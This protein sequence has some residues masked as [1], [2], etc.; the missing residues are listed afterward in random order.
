[1]VQQRVLTV[2]DIC[3]KLKPILGPK[4]DKIY[5]SYITSESRETKEEMAAMIHALYEKHFDNF[6]DADAVLSPPKN[7]ADVNGDYPI[8]RVLYGKKELF[9]FALR[10]HD[11][12][13]HVCISGMSGSGKTTL[14][15]N[16]LEGLIAKDKP[17]LVFDWKKSFRPLLAKDQSLTCFTVG[18]SKLTNNFKININRP[19]K[20]VSPKEWIT[21][22][23]DLVA[24]S[25]FVSYGVHKV[26]VEV[27]DEAFKEWGVYRGSEKYPT[28]NHFKWMLEERLEKAKNR[29]STWIE[30]ALRVATV[31]TFGDFGEVVNYRGESAV[32]VEDIMDRRV[33]FE[34]NALGNIEKKF[35]CEFIL[36]Y[37]YKMRKARQN[38]VD[39]GF[40]YAILVDEAHNIFLKDKTNFVS[41]S[42]TDMV[43]RE[44]REYG[45]S[46]ICLDQHISKLSD[47]VKGNSA[48][49][50][51]FQ[52]QLPEDI[53][54]ISKIM[55]LYDQKELFS[56]LEVGV[57]VVKLS[58]R[59]TK[60]FFMKAPYSAS[61]G[62]RIT[63][64]E[65][66]SRVKKFLSANEF[67][68]N[69]DPSFNSK[70]V[71]GGKFDIN[72]LFKNVKLP[73][74]L[75]LYAVRNERFDAEEREFFMKETLEETPM[76]E[77]V[78]AT[79]KRMLA[80]GH[81]IE[82]IEKEMESVYEPSE[83]VKAMNRIATD[84]LYGAPDT[85]I[86]PQ[87]APMK[88]RE[89]LHEKNQPVVAV[90]I[91]PEFE[92]SLANKIYAQLKEK[93]E[94]TVSNTPMVRDETP[95]EA[96]PKISG[97]KVKNNRPQVVKAKVYK[98]SLQSSDKLPRLSEDESKFVTFLENNPDHE[99]TTVNLYKKIGLSPR[100][101]NKVKGQLLDKNLLKVHEIRSERG[102]MKIVRLA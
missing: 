89:S 10:E 44:M 25:F 42:V 75:N 65:I 24:E 32:T 18:D 57:G 30:S 90:E 39:H 71:T 81:P 79:I 7:P 40:D 54:S 92:N 80:E 95:V 56:G 37:I 60:P 50:I 52:Q 101:G 41:E 36:M 27:M 77:T 102:W 28:W 72:E 62:E 31:L 93:N 26:L 84:E 38:N 4:I 67:L 8:G 20:G 83:V 15:F 35:F 3:R 47:T 99:L 87:E 21:V 68:Q 63:R 66:I 64:E 34:L 17:F 16:V 14:A 46:L 6:L 96:K 91:T 23:C 1:M 2:E 19:P 78:Y 70:L 69:T 33:V 45:V 5:F 53:D 100:K 98:K 82:I 58:D 61:R 86:L 48:C 12:P 85:E 22:I 59:Y 29:E 94:R 74:N 49:H 11:M 88:L 76:S 9:P 13:R 55:H 43:Y 97:E 73:H 51:A